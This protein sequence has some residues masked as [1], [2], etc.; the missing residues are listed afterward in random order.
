MSDEAREADE[1]PWEALRLEHFSG[2]RL[3]LNPGTLGTPSA[4]VRR[5]M[6]AFREEDGE[7]YGLGRS[8][9]RCGGRPLRSAGAPLTP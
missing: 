8:P 9:S 1:A 7:A 4:D 6:T 2:E 5:A 3:N